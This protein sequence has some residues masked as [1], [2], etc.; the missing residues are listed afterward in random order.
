MASDPSSN[1]PVKLTL[2]EAP[3]PYS[4]SR[5]TEC[6]IDLSGLWY[7]LRVLR[8]LDPQSQNHW[9][10]LL[11]GLY[12]PALS[13]FGAA[14][15]RSTH[16]GLCPQGLLSSCQTG[17]CLGPLLCNVIKWLVVFVAHIMCQI[18]QNYFSISKASIRESVWT[19]ILVVQ[20]AHNRSPY[21]VPDH[22][23]M[24]RRNPKAIKR[25]TFVKHSCF[26]T[27]RSEE[28]TCAAAEAPERDSVLVAHVPIVCL[29]QLWNWTAWH[30]FFFA[31]AA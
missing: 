21:W 11:C 12:L 24:G 4:S 6:V 27:I 30:F 1:I 25:F 20:R 26:W 3:V 23:K 13:A 29:H 14:G 5:R 9:H 28:F 7:T 8:G 16:P 17:P 2:S 10:H 31:E 15:G 22:F 18:V 19:W